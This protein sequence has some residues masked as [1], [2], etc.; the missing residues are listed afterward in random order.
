[1]AGAYELPIIGPV[2]DDWNVLKLKGVSAASGDVSGN[3]AF[4]DANVSGGV[5]QYPDHGHFAVF[6]NAE[7]KVSLLTFFDSLRNGAPTIKR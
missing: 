2:H 3:L 6:E 5:L 7:A 1:M 4:A